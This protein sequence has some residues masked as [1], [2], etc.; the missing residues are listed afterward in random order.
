[1]D[2]DGTLVRSDLLWEGMLNATLRRPGQLL[3]IAAAA[4]KGRASV[5][6]AVAAIGAPDLDTLPLE[7]E[8]LAL[9]E[10]R[11][12]AGGTVLLVSG[13]DETQVR[14]LV[15]RANA[16]AGHGSRPGFNLTGRAKLAVIG[17]APGEFDYVGNGLA[18]LPLWSAA[19]TAYGVRLAP[20]T[21]WL[22]R[23]RRP[24][25]IMLD[26]PAFGWRHWFGELRPHQWAKN[27]LLVLPALAAHL[28][29][30]ESFGA[31]MLLG[32]LSWCLGASGGYMLNDL[33][34][35]AADRRHATKCRRAFAAGY[36][37][38][39]VGL[40]SSA[41]LWTTALL[42][43]TRLGTRF[44]AMLLLYLLLSTA[45]STALKRRPIVDVLTLAVLYT[46][47]VIAGAM[48]VSVALS[49]WFLAFSVFL[50]FSLAMLKRVVELRAT[51]RAGPPALPE[52]CWVPGRGYR[53]DDVPVLLTVGT[54]AAM[55]S[56]LVFCLYITSADVTKLYERPDLLWLGLPILLFIQS[57]MW[58]LAG[59]GEMH[60]DPVVFGLTDRQS[61]AAAALLLGV[62]ALAA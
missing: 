57:R 19:R 36:L 16:T 14:G 23:R 13:A 53:T 61:L 56:T 8:V 34:D 30:A 40:L 60:Q 44:A 20:L 54:A 42:L 26:V 29:L 15:P 2:V 46:I 4:I 39:P 33:L 31:R 1:V 38:V 59:R 35:L 47:R 37:S 50:F 10:Q 21:S 55:A 9:I 52:P 62:V 28:P 17:A 49:R 12:A 11:R 5:K 27:V 41:A 7:P 3:R 25:L 6:C 32:V 43:A 24:D 18:D 48:L 58:L 51:Q 45:Y 22:A